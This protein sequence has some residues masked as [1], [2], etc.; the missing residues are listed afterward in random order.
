MSILSELAKR[1]LARRAEVKRSPEKHSQ[2]IP[3][4]FPEFAEKFCTIRSRSSYIPFKLF[5][6]QVQL[7][8][9]LDK[10]PS[11][12]VFKSRQVGVSETII[13]HTLFQAIKNPGFAS[14]VFSIG[15]TEST[16]LNKR[17]RTMPRNLRWEKDNTRELKPNGGGVLYFRPSST[18]AGRGFPSVTRVIFDEAGFIPNLQMLMA[19]AAP[20]Q[21]MAGESTSI[22]TVSTMPEEGTGS[23]F[24]QLFLSGQSTSLLQDKIEEAR[25][26]ESGFLHWLDDNGSCKVLIH[27]KA[28][29]FLDCSEG[30][31]ER[32][33]AKQGISFDQAIR[34]YDLGLPRGDGS[35]FD[36]LLVERQAIGAW[37]QPQPG[38]RYLAGIDPNFGGA[39]Y[40]ALTIWDVTASPYSLV[41]QYHESRQT[42]ERAL[43]QC[44]AILQRYKPTIVAVERNSGGQIILERLTALAP[45]LRF[46][47]V[48]TSRQ[49]KWQNTDRLAIGIEQGEIIF[50]KDWAGVDELKNFNAVTRE[51]SAGHD[52]LVM[53]SAI[54]FAWLHAAYPQTSA[55]GRCVAY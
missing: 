42:V 48:T 37:A 29:P 12:Q 36:P 44:L 47:A 50:P 43:T 34:E 45:G 18:S 14:L 27:R 17:M 38:R 20:A 6:Y 8:K 51:A 26:G 5:P 31:V 19:A 23:F 15:Q 49:S 22:I 28:N 21:E 46:E 1:E 53:S 55:W 40:F 24:W 16:E 4:K 11:V 52:D 54:A 41:A 33:A 30:Y 10:Y 7:A 2:T 3:A 39:D 13:A 35:L 25:S 32:I 9:L